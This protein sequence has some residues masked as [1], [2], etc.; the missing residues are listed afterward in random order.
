MLIPG[1]G[2]WPPSRYTASRPRANRILLR[3]SGTRNMFAN[4]SKNLM[5]PSDSRRLLGGCADHLR[6][7][8][9][10][11]Y[12]IQCRLGKLVGLHR[13][14][15]RQ[16]AGPQDLESVAQLADDT[17]LDE[18]IDVEGIAFELLQASQVDDGEMLLENI[19]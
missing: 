15:A 19:R 11:L 9:G 5:V 1:V 10:L 7:P 8:S 18:P 14:F 16:L 3:R 6:R 2:M 4:A 17:Q 13:D 12:L